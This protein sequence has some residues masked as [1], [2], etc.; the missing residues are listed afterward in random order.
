MA[1]IAPKGAAAPILLSEITNDE[2]EL[3]ILKK[4]RRR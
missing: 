1:A 4:D 2:N 3:A